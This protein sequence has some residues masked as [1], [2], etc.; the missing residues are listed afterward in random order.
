MVFLL[1]EVEFLVNVGE[2]NVA[3]R[4]FRCV[5]IKN[6]CEEGSL[7]SLGALL[8]IYLHTLKLIEN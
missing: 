8:Q 7:P 4:A 3:K 1:S 2:K 5:L 6:W